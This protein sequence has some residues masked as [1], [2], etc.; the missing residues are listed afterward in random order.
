M[1]RCLVVV[2]EPGELVVRVN[3]HEDEV[4]RDV[5]ADPALA[6]RLLHLPRRCCTALDSELSGAFDLDSGGCD[7]EIN[8]LVDRG[9]S[10][11]P[12]FPADGYR[13]DL[14]VVGAKARLAVECDGDA[15]HGPEAYE[16][17]LARQRDLERCG[18]RFFRIRESEFYADRPAVLA[19]LWDALH[20]LDIHASGWT[21]EAEDQPTVVSSRPVAVV[22]PA[23]DVPVA[24][25]PGTS[26][27][28][29]DADDP[30]DPEQPVS[31]MAV[32]EPAVLPESVVAI[33][34]PEALEQMV[35]E[36]EEVSPPAADS[37]LAAYQHFGGTVVQVGEA[38]RQDLLSGLVRLVEA[39]GPVLGSRLHTAYVRAS[40]AV[41]V[42]KLVAGE[43]NKAISQAVRKGE[44]IEDNPLGESGIK[45]RTYRLPG[46]P[47]VRMR[48]LGPRSLDEVPPAELAAML[49]HVA[50]RV[51][52]VSEGALQRAVL[53]LLGLKRLTDNVKSRFAAVQALR[54]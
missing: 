43:L 12:Q 14:V 25:V 8:R 16:R 5:G 2:V 9:Y 54:S 31:K 28:E 34:L 29:P 27:S 3:D 37:A 35:V 18:W 51:G 20:E 22:E 47:E 48:Q 44:L 10:V 46:Q 6:P 11:V 33:E 39:E 49:D 32:A 40:G 53:E 7:F 15:W 30:A 42:T 50:E 52:D 19:R 26:V 4:H 17:D 23:L 45:P 24:I 1:Q 13:I 36:H 38:S 41:R 21:P